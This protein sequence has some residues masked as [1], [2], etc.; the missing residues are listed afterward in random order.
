MIGDY[1]K[2]C[3]FITEA[4]N[5][6]QPLE[7][8][9]G[10]L[11]KSSPFTPWD[12]EQSRKVAEFAKNFLETTPEFELKQK[13]EEFLAK[14]CKALVHAYR[15]FIQVRVISD[16]SSLLKI[17]SVVVNRLLPQSETKE[18]DAKIQT[19]REKLLKKSEQQAAIALPSSLPN[20]SKTDSLA[21]ALWNMRDQGDV[22]LIWGDSKDQ[23]CCVHE[24]VLK[25]RK[26]A[27]LDAAM[28]K[29]W[30]NESK[31][32]SENK[33]RKEGENKLTSETSTTSKAQQSSKKMIH[34]H[35]FNFT[36]H[37]VERLIEWIYF[38]S[39]KSVTAEELVYLYHLA[40]VLD[41]KPLREFCL[42]NLS[43]LLLKTEA[44]FSLYEKVLNSKVEVSFP[45]LQ[46]LEKNLIKVVV[47]Q[48]PCPSRY[49]PQGDVAGF[50]FSLYQDYLR[51]FLT[52][53]LTGSQSLDLRREFNSKVLDPGAFLC[54]QMKDT[55][56]PAILTLLGLIHLYSE[57]IPGLTLTEKESM[58]YKYF[59]QGKKAGSK[60]ATY[61]FGLCL[62]SGRGIA[63]NEREGR[64]IINQS[65][66]DKAEAFASINYGFY[67]TNSA[68]VLGSRVELY[69]Q[70]SKYLDKY[71]GNF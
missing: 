16:Q 52:K 65:N 23:R 21:A 29:Q 69:L 67:E 38:D 25:A 44:V 49:R 62:V 8:N 56:D 53:L 42:E 60:D 28:S 3:R 43:L 63:Q 46:L 54:G 13:D 2:Q 6:D 20:A 11:K 39:L 32:Q 48:V 35:Q 58:A 33:D 34:L 40:E 70:S 71:R 1:L 66:C 15:Q 59:E 12:S 61:C 68:Y 9:D 19:A 24:L 57:N 14:A 64:K 37:L 10:I 47:E 5:S 27:F 7:I 45:L 51:E 26:V 18:Q 30:Q 22:E 4:L 41:I 36:P 17:N 55:K 31:I 50:S